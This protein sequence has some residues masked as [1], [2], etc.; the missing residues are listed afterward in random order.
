MLLYGVVDRSMNSRGE[1]SGRLDVN[2]MQRLT[3][4]VD[5]AF[6][7]FFCGCWGS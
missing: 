5:E 7:E 4:E 6:S 1:S 3:R 2:V